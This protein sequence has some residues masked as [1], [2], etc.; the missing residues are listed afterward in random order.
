MRRLISRLIDAY[1]SRVDRKHQ[2]DPV[3][4]A[5]RRELESVGKQFEAM[6]YEELLDCQELSFTRRVSEI[7]VT[8]STDL[9]VVRPNGD[10]GFCI[11]A[12][13]SSR[14]FRWQPS[15]QFYKRKNGGVYY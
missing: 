2:A 6:T 9:F 13:T 15:Y 12:S 14:R 1:F 5:L 3:V 8:F 7:E 11:D 10:L 4:Q